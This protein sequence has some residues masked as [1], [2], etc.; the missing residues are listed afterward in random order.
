ELRRVAWRPARLFLRPLEPFLLDCVGK[1]PGR[2]SRAGLEPIW[3]WIGRDLLPEEAKA[4]SQDVGRAL[5]AGSDTDADSLVNAFQDRVVVAI[6]RALAAVH[7]DER[8]IGRLAGQVGTP[9][10]IEDLVDL[11]DIQRARAPLAAFD[12]RLAG[13][14]GTF[15]GAHVDAVKAAL[16]LH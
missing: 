10:A 13:H 15:S 11:R 14:I 8:A 5:V 12:E 2:M 9:D 16:D 6:V 1:R 4:F 3:T 7:G